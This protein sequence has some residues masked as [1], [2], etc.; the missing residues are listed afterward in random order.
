MIVKEYLIKVTGKKQLPSYG[1]GGGGGGGGG[2]LEAEQ[3]RLNWK[4]V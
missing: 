4:V 2:G 1:A 3:S